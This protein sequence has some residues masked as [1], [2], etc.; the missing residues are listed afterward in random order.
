MV[1]K[2][3]KKCKI[4]KIERQRAKEI[5]EDCNVR[6]KLTRQT[7]RKVERLKKSTKIGH[8]ELK[9]T[10]FT[11]LEIGKTIFT[12]NRHTDIPSCTKLG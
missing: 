8:L 7:R 5:R 11:N 12:N 10:I 9:K 1:E 4:V 6:L 2:E 3:Q